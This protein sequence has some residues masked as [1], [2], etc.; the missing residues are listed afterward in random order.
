MTCFGTVWNVSCF[1]YYP[2]RF[3]F[4]T[5]VLGLPPSLSPSLNWGNLRPSYH[6]ESMVELCR[7][8]RPERLS[9]SWQNV[10]PHLDFHCSRRIY[11]RLK[12]TFRPC[13]LFQSLPIS[14][15][16]LDHY[17]LL[18]IYKSGV[19]YCHAKDQTFHLSSTQFSNSGE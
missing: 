12:E 15:T 14:P 1:F 17:A 3:F 6:I 5:K 19:R 2:W 13:T 7:S 11:V 16:K 18:S 8:R 10:V 9:I 4:L